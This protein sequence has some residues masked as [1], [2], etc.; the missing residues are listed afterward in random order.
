[1]PQ[2]INDQF[3]STNTN[4]HNRTKVAVGGEWQPDAYSNKYLRRVQ[5]RLGASFATSYYK[6]DGVDGPKE[7]GVSAGLGLP[8]SRNASNRSMVNVSFQWLRS[9][10]GNSSLMSENYLRLSVGIT[11]NERWFMKRRIQ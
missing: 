10:P 4:Y 8:V 11:F 1:M 5:Y 9:A 7:F 6:V 2:I 3:V